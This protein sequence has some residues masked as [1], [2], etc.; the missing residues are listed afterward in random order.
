MT[1]A[2][3]KVDHAADKLRGSDVEMARVPM[4]SPPGAR[5]GAAAIPQSPSRSET[6]TSSQSCGIRGSDG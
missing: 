6:A 5:S 2:D 1:T 3:E 4:T